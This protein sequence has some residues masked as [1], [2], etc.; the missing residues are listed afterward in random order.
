MDFFVT[1]FGAKV[2]DALQTAA[3][4]KAIDT[5]YLAGGGRVVV[6]TGIFRTGGLRLR[7]NVTLY[8]KSGAV[9][10]GSSDP[11]DYFVFQKDELEPVP[12]VSEVYKNT[13]RDP[14]C[15]W[16]NGL[17]KAIHAENIAVIGEPGSY[18][19]GVNCYDS[20]GEEDYRGPHLIH[21]FYCK[22]VTLAGYTI[23]RSANWAH[24]IVYSQDITARN[25]TVYGGH[26]GF[27]I[28][29]CDHV[30]VQS[31][32]FLT[33]DDCIAGFD[34]QDVSISDCYL[35]SSCSLFRFG[36]TNV[37]I[38]RCRSKAPASFGYRGTMPV[39]EKQQRIE[40]TDK[41]RHNTGNV[42]LYY[43]DHRLDMRT[44]PGDI[45]I[46]DCDFEG[47][48]ALFQ[49]DFGEHMCWCCNRPLTSIR[50]ERCKC[51]NL[52][53]PSLIKASAQQ[54]IVFELE[55]MTLSAREGCQDIALA[56]ISNYKLF[57]M[58]N[59]SFERIQDPRIILRSQGNLDLPE[60]VR[61]VW[62]EE[63]YHYTVT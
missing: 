47:P 7:S 15:R 44:I 27:D 23:R 50:F 16:N 6:P 37:R 24:N 41:C 1:D 11:E 25:V 60:Q 9:L 26:D 53:A 49:M 13:F 22:N 58:K 52:G 38:N 31:C 61:T 59:I 5:C 4:Q 18:L 14:C 57:S 29:S 8:L 20:L 42:F 56:E 62:D 34:N 32:T 10:E 17:I 51:L 45:V 2:S 54:P 28:F 30:T 63:G 21:C 19:D 12:P 55:D 33:G 43:C 36:G 35:E 39:T 46:S 48:D 3:I 40:A